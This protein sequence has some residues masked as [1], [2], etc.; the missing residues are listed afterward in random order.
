MSD[1]NP[2]EYDSAAWWNWTPSESTT[3]KTIRQSTTKNP[4]DY[5]S[6]EWWKDNGN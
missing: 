6:P 2:H 4:P 1:T 3:K 5:D